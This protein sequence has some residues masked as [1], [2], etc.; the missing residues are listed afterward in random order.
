MQHRVRQ[1]R[2]RGEELQRVDAHGVRRAKVGRDERVDESVAM[3]FDYVT[4]E[5]LRDR[6]RRGRHRRRDA[7]R[8]GASRRAG[9]DELWGGSN[10][11][12]VDDGTRVGCR[13]AFK[14]TA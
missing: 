11:A 3:V 8:R 2:Y 10:A 1:H 6:E 4:L 14:S 12:A 9:R 7:R 13:R 5:L